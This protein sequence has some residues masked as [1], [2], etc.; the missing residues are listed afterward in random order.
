MVD[1]TNNTV[2]EKLLAE[3]RDWPERWQGVG[4]DVPLGREIAK[5]ML[6][7]LRHLVASGLAP[8]TL[9]RHFGNAWLLGG[10]IVRKASLDPPALTARGVNLLL[11]QVGD[12][13]GPLLHGYATE[14]E[15]RSFD[16]T[17]RRLWRFLGGK[18]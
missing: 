11:E 15:Q 7:F 5:A 10:E 18:H 13:G 4:R 3:T 8:S 9:R 17:C 2:G 6:L 16:A 14:E 1:S 12:D